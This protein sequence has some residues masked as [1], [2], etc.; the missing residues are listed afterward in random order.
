MHTTPL[1]FNKIFKLLVLSLCLLSFGCATTYPKDF[2]KV[3]EN[4]LELRQL[5]TRLFE[6]EKE[7]EILSSSTGVLQDMG[8]TLDDSATN[9][10]LVVA[11]KD[12][13]ATD[14]GQVTLATLAVIL[15]A[16]GGTGSNAFDHIDAVQ[17]IRASVVSGLS[18]EKNRVKV[19][20]TFQRIVWN[21][22]GNV[23]KME[24]L[25][26]PDLYQGFYE[27]LSKAVFLEGQQI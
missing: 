25:K 13:D 12:R 4:S 19:R 9:L 2:L 5:Q 8:F 7:R 18:A 22:A 1:G 24:T 16:F 11:S 27:K 3:A 14:A 10:G 6:T 15:G 17:K 21:K 23:S 26:D 20:V